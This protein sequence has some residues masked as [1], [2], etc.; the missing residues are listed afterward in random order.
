MD[1]KPYITLENQ[2]YLLIVIYD[3][4]EDTSSFINIWVPFNLTSD[5]M[6]KY[7]VKKMIKKWNSLF[8]LHSSNVISTFLH[9]LNFYIIVKNN[10]SSLL[11]YHLFWYSF[12]ITCRI[13]QSIRKVQK[14][15][16][17]SSILSLW[18]ADSTLQA[19]NSNQDHPLWW[20]W[21]APVARC[22]WCGLCLLFPLA[23]HS[24]AA[25][26]STQWKA[27]SQFSLL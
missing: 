19:R 11:S 7:E 23:S 1:F 26:P 16:V 4:K 21:C 18:L 14:I 6:S 2:I 17:D 22:V 27:F 20:P 5:L 15:T 13:Q 25:K 3:L 9:Q 12:G 24:L 10:F 8:C